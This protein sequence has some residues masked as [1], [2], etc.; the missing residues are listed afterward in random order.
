MEELVVVVVEGEV[1]EAEGG[2]C[3]TGGSYRS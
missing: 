3:S 2:G 1:G